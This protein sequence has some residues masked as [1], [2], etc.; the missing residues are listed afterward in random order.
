MCVVFFHKVILRSRRDVASVMCF[1]D[2]WFGRRIKFVSC[3]CP[4]ALVSFQSPVPSPVAKDPTLYVKHRQF[5]IIHNRVT[6]LYSHC[7][8]LFRIHEHFTS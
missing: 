1:R 5:L 7:M 2:V 6:A 4:G 3:F 8:A